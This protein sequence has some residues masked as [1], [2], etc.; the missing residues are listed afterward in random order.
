MRQVDPVLVIDA[1]E[2]AESRLEAAAPSHPD[3][4]GS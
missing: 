3:V 1:A 4:T 2:P